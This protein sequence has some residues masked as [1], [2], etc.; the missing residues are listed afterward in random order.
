MLYLLGEI[1]GRIVE[2]LLRNRGL[3]YITQLGLV[4]NP[5]MI[6]EEEDIIFF[7]G[8]KEQLKLFPKNLNRQ[9]RFYHI[10]K[11]QINKN[12]LESLLDKLPIDKVDLMNQY[13][14]D[15]YSNY[16]DI[17]LE[18]IQTP[19]SVT[20][21]F[22]HSY[23]VVRNEEENKNQE[24]ESFV[25]LADFYFALRISKLLYG[26]KKIRIIPKN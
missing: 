22:G 10:G 9:N 8:T 11:N 23:N 4:F 7:F 16:L 24:N 20:D 18:K 14:F 3:D 12:F 6:L 25:L 15:T 5:N 13:I 19:F 17:P 2:P 21:H 26:I 1:S